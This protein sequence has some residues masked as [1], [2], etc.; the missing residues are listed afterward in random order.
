[1]FTDIKD[2]KERRTET[3]EANIYCTGGYW[4]GCL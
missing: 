3:N 4:E 1:M 2:S